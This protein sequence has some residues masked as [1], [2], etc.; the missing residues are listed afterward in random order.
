[1]SLKAA[2][3]WACLQNVKIKVWVMLNWRRK[4]QPPWWDVHGLLWFWEFIPIR[5]QAELRQHQVS[6]QLLCCEVQSR[7][8]V[9]SADW[10]VHLKESWEGNCL[11]HCASES[12]TF[13]E[14]HN[15]F[16]NWVL[17]SRIS[18]ISP[19]SWKHTCVVEDFGIKQNL[20]PP[21]LRQAI[22]ISEYNYM[23]S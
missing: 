9:S 17:T 22:S 18:K 2:E 13:L 5:S 21:P 23:N 10:L 4:P 3:R 16:S 19:C 12:K 8:Q 11:L 1:M 14:Q 7:E 20:I 15:Y 6:Q